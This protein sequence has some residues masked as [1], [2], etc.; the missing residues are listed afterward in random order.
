MLCYGGCGI[1]L[2]GGSQQLH[3]PR[4]TISASCHSIRSIVSH[5]PSLPRRTYHHYHVA[6]TI[7]T[8]SHV[9]FIP[10]GH[11]Y[12]IVKALILSY[13]IHIN[14]ATTIAL[15]CILLKHL[16]FSVSIYRFSSWNC[17]NS[18][19]NMEKASNNS[20]STEFCSVTFTIQNLVCCQF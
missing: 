14:P 8:M 5:V 17:R 12:I 10:Q 4:Q 6:C 19:R 9:L 13:C 18:I 15:P 16:L 7:T 11:M 1:R 20:V 3:Q 2:T